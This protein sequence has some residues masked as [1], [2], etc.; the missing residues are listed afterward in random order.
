MISKSWMVGLVV[1]AVGGVATAQSVPPAAG[2]QAEGAPPQGAAGGAGGGGTPARPSDAF[3]QAGGSLFRMGNGGTSGG[4]TAAARDVSVFAV[5]PPEPRSIKKF[6][7]ITVIIREESQSK[8]EA[9]TDLKKNTDFNLLLEQY[10]KFSLGELSLKGREPLTSQPQLKFQGDRNFKGEGTVERTDS[11]S[12]RVQAQVIDVKPNGLLI[13]QATKQIKNDEEE[14]KMVLTGMVRAED[15][16][17]DNSV[18]STQLADL[19][20]EK[21]TKG[22]ARDSSKRG[23]IPTLVDK[24]NPF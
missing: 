8:A 11:V 9:S 15:V 21:T 13:V 2:G 3:K 17:P 6:D 24:I 14:L 19:S 7:L 1:S 20:L 5:R 12:A 18:L 22:A 4:G 23:W 16:T 10:L